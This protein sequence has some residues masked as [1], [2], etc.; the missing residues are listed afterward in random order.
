MSGLSIRLATPDDAVIVARHRVG[1]SR[2][3]GRVKNDRQAAQLL[4]VSTAVLATA[5]GDGSYVGWLASNDDGRVVGGVGVH[6]KPQL[7]R[8]SPD[9]KSV[10][11]ARV[12]LV[13]NVYTE[14]DA[15]RRGVARE[16]M[17]AL[18]DWAKIEGCDRV[19]LHASDMG[20]PLYASLGFED[21]NEMRW[22]PFDGSH[23]AE[24][25]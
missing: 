14:P 6:L 4:A 18:M 12:P 16:L 17:R 11:T 10:S 15:R 19:L 25:E 7:P 21:S 20:R 24:L 8:I 2:D 13:V 9:G 3:M 1:M 23:A 5:L 22:L